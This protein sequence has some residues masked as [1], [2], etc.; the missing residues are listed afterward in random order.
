MRKAYR[1]F[2]HIRIGKLYQYNTL[3]NLTPKNLLLFFSVYTILLFIID[4]LV[5][6][7][8]QPASKRIGLLLKLPFSLS[9]SLVPCD[10]LKINSF[11]AGGDAVCATDF[12]LILLY[13]YFAA[14]SFLLIFK[15]KLK[16]LNWII[17]FIAI[18]LIAGFF[19]ILKAYIY[20][21]F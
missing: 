20:L 16:F 13:I 6:V 2:R 12:G 5:V 9:L 17:G 19:I 18:N 11:S 8:A 3:L 14:P 21:D 7:L 15:K 10:V 1:I 4:A